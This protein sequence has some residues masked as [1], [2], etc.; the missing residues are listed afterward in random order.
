MRNDELPRFS[1]LVFSLSSSGGEGWGGEGRFL[2]CAL[3]SQLGLS[4][5]HDSWE[6]NRMKRKDAKNRR[7]VLECACLFSAPYTHFQSRRDYV[8]QPRVA[9]HE[10]P[11]EISP[12]YANPEGVAA[13]VC[14]TEQRNT[15][16]NPFRVAAPL[17]WPTQGSSF[18]ATLG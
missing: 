4:E 9:R 8:L 15:G 18:L 7:K 5:T 11:W 12:R 17:R 13:A 6:N 1:L 2:T 10:L 14:C 3:Q 16:P